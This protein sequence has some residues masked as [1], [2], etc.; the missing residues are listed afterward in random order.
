MWLR[1]YHADGLSLDAVH[2]FADGGAVHL[3]EQLAADVRALAARL[4]RDL[5]LIA[6]SDTNDPRLVTAREAGGYSLDAHWNDD[7]HHSVHAA[8][9]GERQGYYRDFGSMAAVAKTLTRAY[10]HDGIWSSFRGRSHGRP[11]DVLRMSA[12]RFVG[13][14]QNHDQVGNRPA[15]GSPP[16]CP[17]TC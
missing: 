17:S 5:V 1:D 4:N 9:T 13:C 11:V 3:L 16:A 2:A 8:I 10:F 15:T 14:L 6:E 7:F 12:H